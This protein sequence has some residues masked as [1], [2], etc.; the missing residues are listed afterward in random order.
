MKPGDDIGCALVLVIMA[1][2]V[3]IAVIAFSLYSMASVVAGAVS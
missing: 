1:G 2:L 3:A